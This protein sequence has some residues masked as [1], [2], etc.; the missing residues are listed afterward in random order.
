MPN[1]SLN[2]SRDVVPRRKLQE[3]LDRPGRDLPLPGPAHGLAVEELPAR[4]DQAPQGADGEPAA[5]GSRPDRQGLAR[6]DGFT[7][8]TADGT[9][10]RFDTTET[11]FDA[12]GFPPQHL[13]EHRALA[14]PVRVT[15][16]V[17][18]GANRVVKL[19]DAG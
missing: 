12:A 19:E 8:R 1:P 5:H 4:E 14:E 15:Y 18:D 6:I 7:L 3:A 2:Q 17:K 13:Q 11:R 9:E 10:L 16:Q